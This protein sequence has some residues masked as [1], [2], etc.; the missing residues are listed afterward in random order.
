MSWPGG[1][2]IPTRRRG[3]APAHHPRLLLRGY[4]V[5]TLRL[6]RFR[7]ALALF[8]G[9]SRT[10]MM[11][12]LLGPCSPGRSCSIG[13]A[14]AII[15]LDA[16][17]WGLRLIAWI[18]TVLGA[19]AVVPWNPKR[20]RNRSCLPPTWTAEER[21]PTHQYSPLL[22]SRLQL[23]QFLPLTTLTPIW[24]VGSGKASRSDRCWHDC[25]RASLPI[26]QDVPISFGPQHECWHICPE[27]HEGSSSRAS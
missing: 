15:R 10:Y 5:H 2:M 25:G 17:Y 18:H 1:G 9:T 22:R 16:G 11:R 27:P 19:V 23:V 4:R 3:H 14:Q 6:S 26:R 7:L 8:L 12:P 24:L 13:C 20:Q 21:G